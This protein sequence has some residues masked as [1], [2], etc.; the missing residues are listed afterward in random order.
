LRRI[1]IMENGTVVRMTLTRKEAAHYLGVHI[2]TIDRSSIPR[3]RIG[4]KVLFRIDTLEKFL[5]GEVV[6]EGKQQ[7]R[8]PK[9]CT[10]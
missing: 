9:Q 6:P 5:E 2:N 3:L 7:M 4:G 1:A 8:R 10:K